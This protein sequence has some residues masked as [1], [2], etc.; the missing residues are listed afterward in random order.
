MSQAYT[1]K[2]RSSHVKV[3]FPENTTE[4]HYAAIVEQGKKIENDFVTNGKEIEGILPTGT[5]LQN[6]RYNTS[7]TH[8]YGWTRDGYHMDYGLARYAASCLLFENLITPK[9]QINMDNNTFRISNSND[10]YGSYTTPVNDSNKSIA[11]QA[12][13]DAM[14]NKFDVTKH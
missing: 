14:N 12:A 1:E 2:E 10:A 7:I 4:L 8:W 3:D 13:R 11:I 6:L 9:Y 5:V